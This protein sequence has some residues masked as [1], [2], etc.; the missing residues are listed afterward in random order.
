MQLFMSVVAMRQNIGEAVELVRLAKELG[1]E[2]IRFGRLGS[3]L[4]LGN[5]KDELIY[6]P[7]Y[8]SA[9]LEK[10]KREGEKTGVRVVT[11]VIM[12]GSRIDEKAAERERVEI[13][14]RPF[15]ES[16]EHY[17]ELSEKYARLKELHRFEH[18]LYS[19][20]GAISCRGLCHWIGFGLYVNSSGKV[21]PC[22]E[23]P[24]NREQER[25][26]EIIDQNCSELKEFRRRFISGKVPKV[27][28]DCAFIMSDEIG[29][30]KVDLQEY[31]HYFQEKA[32]LT[33]ERS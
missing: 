3:N 17:A 23:V 4:F 30:L 16:E 21:R 27:C 6:Y 32:G 33:D 25:R 15:F 14:A 26:Q 8:A 7:N 1:F 5:E 10:A 13:Y 19:T 24:Y 20:E 18:Q 12:R 9:M 28:M 29:C 11:P 2:E 31:K 22:S